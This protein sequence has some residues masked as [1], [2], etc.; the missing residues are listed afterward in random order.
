MFLIEK[1]RLWKLCPALTFSD[2]Q[3]AEEWQKKVSSSYNTLNVLQCLMVI[4]AFL[5]FETF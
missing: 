5:F 1:C 2:Q 4:L 3:S